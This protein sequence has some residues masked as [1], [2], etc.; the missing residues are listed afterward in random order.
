MDEDLVKGEEELVNTTERCG[1]EDWLD[2][3]HEVN[4]YTQRDDDTVSR[5]KCYRVY[6]SFPT[7]AVVILGKMLAFVRPFY[8]ERRQKR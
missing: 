2:P 1:E 3:G 8:C 6:M 7:R 4:I 5:S